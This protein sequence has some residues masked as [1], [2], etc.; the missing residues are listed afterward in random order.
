MR[1]EPSQVSILNW[2]VGDIL[3]VGQVGD[4]Y[5][6]TDCQ[7]TY[8]AQPSWLEIEPIAEEDKVNPRLAISFSL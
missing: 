1:I 5:H 4:Q 6:I 3:V 8:N 2:K 7:E